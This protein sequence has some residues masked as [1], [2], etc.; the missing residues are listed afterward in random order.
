MR[1]LSWNVNSVR[2][3]LEA[4]RRVVRKYQPDVVC[5][6]ETKV[7]DALFPREAFTRMGF[8]DLAVAGQKGYHG[9]AIASRASITSRHRQ[10]LASS[11]D[12]RHLSVVTAG[13]EIHNVYVPAGGPLPDPRLNPAFAHKLDYLRALAAWTRSW[14]EPEEHPRVLV[15]DLNVAPLEHD[16]WDHRRLRRTITHTEAE[17][18]L[19]EAAQDALPWVDVGRRFV[20]PQEKLYTWWSHRGDWRSRMQGR[21]L[22]HAWVSSA[23]APRLRGFQVAVEVRG[24]RRPSDHAPVI[25]D[26]DWPRADAA[27]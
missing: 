21:R 8:V 2:V 11:E 26:L 1:L 20:P 16:V 9:V 17:V 27:R 15:G 7:V 3:R 19:L 5:L 18:S 4:L 22:D 24:W 6:Q 13:L 12:Q 25:V 14:P 10:A 23:L